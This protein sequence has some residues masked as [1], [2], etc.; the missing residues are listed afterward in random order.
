MT[1]SG[2]ST[3]A[4]RRALGAVLAAEAVSVAGNRI[5]L[6]AIPWF[7]LDTTGDPA[8]A[9]LSGVAYF[10]P[11]V[12]AG[13]FGGPLVDR[14]GFIRSSVH[15]DLAS[16]MTVA[17][18]PVL[19]M[20]GH[21]PFWLL[22]VLTFAGSMLDVPGTTA[23][24]S[25]VPDLAEACGMRL[26][27]AMSA[28][29]TVM[30]VAQLTGGL[31]GGVLLAA[32]GPIL[33]LYVDAASF[34]VSALVVGLTV[35]RASPRK[36]PHLSK[37]TSRYFAELTEGLR[38]I[39]E[40]TLLPRILVVFMFANMADNALFTVLL[41]TLA[42]QVLDNPLAL[43]LS[44]AAFGAGALVGAVLFGAVGHRFPRHVIVTGALLISGAPKFFVIAALPGTPTLVVTMALAGIAAGPVNPLLTA[45][46]FS[47]IPSE[48]RG[49]VSG[50]IM[51]AVVAA[52]PVG[53]FGAG[54]LVAMTSLTTALLVIAAGYLLVS[55][56]PALHPA[57]R[58]ATP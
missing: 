17:A 37:G 18:I 6:I 48:L 40:D 31:L 56:Y 2:T 29:E 4:A 10:V 19:Y 30:R 51:A 14:M 42:E 16:G 8:R 7:V 27:R 5:A 21:L 39:R 3:R 20:L 32:L 58:T 28:H 13:L 22:L 57:W 55:L 1:S 47:R 45:V 43:G 34:L 49:R 41:P 38:F 53:I 9:G 50:A 23:R 26:E 44:V 36:A 15:A 54:L 12:L 33:V 52:V 35:P 11:V 46:Q 24:R 25:L